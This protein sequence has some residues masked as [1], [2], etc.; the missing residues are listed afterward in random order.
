MPAD[1]PAAWIYRATWDDEKSCVTTLAE[2][3][4]SMKDAGIENHALIIIGECLNLDPGARSLLYT[5]GFEG[6]RT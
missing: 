5:E 1:T 4:S 6:G 2:L 3:Q